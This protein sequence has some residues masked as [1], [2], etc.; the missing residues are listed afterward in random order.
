MKLE[1]LILE[2]YKGSGSKI[3]IRF[4]DGI[5]YLI[6]LNGSG[7]TL[8]GWALQHLFDESKTFFNSK[9]RRRMITEGATKMIVGG[10]FFDKE[11]DKSLIIKKS[12]TKNDNPRL[13]IKSSDNSINTMKDVLKMIDPLF[14]RPFDIVTKSSKEQ[15]ELIGVNTF[16]YDVSIRNAK[17]VLVPFRAEI[18]RCKK[19]LESYDEVPEKIEKISYAELFEEKK[20]IKQFNATQSELEDELLHYNVNSFIE[21]IEREYPDISFI[22]KRNKIIDTLNSLKIPESYKNTEEIQSKINS[23]EKTNEKALAYQEYKKVESQK[24]EATKSFDV[25]QKNVEKAQQDKI[26]Y[27]KSCKVMNGISFDD[28]GGLQIS[29]FGQ[30]NAYLNEHFFSRGQILKL[31]FQ[32]AIMKILKAR[33]EKQDIIPLIFIDNAESLDKE[34]IKY[35]QDMV[36]KHNIQVVLTIVDDKAKAGQYSIMIDEKTIKGYKE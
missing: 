10:E 19:V 2:N 16:K 35:I 8:I 30:T 7:K 24:D 31:S 22:E 15:A 18:N 23:A 13:V 12:N 25:E 32:F 20:R 6:G 36:E 14:L 11:T 1:K 27:I 3:E 28:E 26:D 9:Y 4:N 5:T 34:N 17:A 21:D 29:A 33:K